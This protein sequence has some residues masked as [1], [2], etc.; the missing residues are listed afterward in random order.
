[1]R[2]SNELGSFIDLER[3]MS[4]RFN[5]NE[6]NRWALDVISL[7]GDLFRIRIS[8]ASLIDAVE[9][10]RKH[11]E[12]KCSIYGNQHTKTTKA[13]NTME[14]DTMDSTTLKSKSS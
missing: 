4:Y 3:G 2:I 13:Y 9:W 6:E 8:F 5:L 10:L 14:P 11:I 1:M 7:D 12:G